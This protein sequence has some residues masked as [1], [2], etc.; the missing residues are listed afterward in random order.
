[1]NMALKAKQSTENLFERWNSLKY[2]KTILYLLFA[3]CALA[4]GLVYSFMIPLGQVPDEFTHYEMMEQEFGTEG[5]IA[6]LKSE[7]YTAGGYE[8]MPW[9]ADVKVDNAAAAAVAGKQFSRR[10][11]LT[12]F[13]PNIMIFRHLPAGIG[14]Y[15]GTAL[16]LPM[17]TCTYLA[18]IF[19]VLFFAGIGTL[20]LKTAPVKK[21]IFALCLLIPE[22]LQQCASV[23]YDAT[24]IPLAILLFAWILRLYEDGTTVRWKHM[25]GIA[26]ISFV[27]LITKPPYALIALTV[28]MIP[29]GQFELKIGKKIEMARLI[30][31]YWYIAGILVLLLCGG[32]VYYLRN[33]STMK[34]MIADVLCIGDFARMLGRTFKQLGYEYLHMMVGVFGWLDSR[35]SYGFVALFVGMTV[36]LNA[37]RVEKPEREL[38]AGRRWWMV[39]VFLLALLLSLIALQEYSYQILG[40]DVVGGIDVF[41]QHVKN[42]DT[43]IG[44]QGRYIIPILPVLLVAVSGKTERKASKGYY[45]LQIAYYVYA[46]ITVIGILQGRYWA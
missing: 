17:M 26:G 25:L 11:G 19:S 32:G 3:V 38:N 24:T 30:R 14:F 10:P 21:E 39:F 41:Q 13:H 2:R 4:Q 20:A 33:T 15:L 5:Y 16:G 37:A 22:S 23:S 34:T 36:W 44:F 27:L 1:M 8:N 7:V 35:V 12:E 43:I 45:L 31:K 18:E 40:A 9:R 46:F 6:E 42:L 28:F 29:A